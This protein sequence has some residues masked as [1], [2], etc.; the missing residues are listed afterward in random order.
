MT[1][2]KTKLSLSLAA[3]GALCLFSFAE[4]ADAQRG[5]G[6]GGGGAARGGGSHQVRSN[7]SSS[8]NHN[9][10][11]NVNRNTNRNVN[12]NVNRD[13]NV[14]RNVDIDVDHDYDWDDRY[15][16]V[17]RAAATTAAVATTAAIMGSYYR[18]LPPN[19]VTVVRV[20]ISYYQCGSV[21]YQPTYRGSTVE[22]LVVTAP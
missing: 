9:A 21:W 10:N 17:A 16:P 6:R 2:K 15:H 7:A 1:L 22:Y 12:R 5:G 4:I 13:V 8:V 19:C 11:R 3:C 18:S 14:N 20:G